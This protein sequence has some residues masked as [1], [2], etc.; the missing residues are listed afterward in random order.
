MP[1][2]YEEFAGATTNLGR[3]N[4]IFF[5]KPI[6][7]ASGWRSRIVDLEKPEDVEYIRR[8]FVTHSHMPLTLC[9][10]LTHTHTHIHTLTNMHIHHMCAFAH[11]HSDTF[12][13]TQIHIHTHMTHAHRVTGYGRVIYVTI[14]YIFSGFNSS[15]GSSSITSVINLSSLIDHL[16]YEC[17]S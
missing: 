6:S 5:I 11:M 3:D 15:V 10:T 8:C 7:S 4:R 12:T 9:L 16:V 14:V 2:Q 1:Q 13:C 17:L